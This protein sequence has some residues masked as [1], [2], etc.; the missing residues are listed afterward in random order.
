MLNVVN[1][2]LESLHFF[3]MTCC[4]WYGRRWEWLLLLRVGVLVGGVPQRISIMFRRRR[5]RQ[6]RHWT[7]N[8]TTFSGFDVIRCAVSRMFRW[9][10]GVYI[11]IGVGDRINFLGRWMKRK[12]RIRLLRC[13]RRRCVLIGGQGYCSAP[14][15]RSAVT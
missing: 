15:L 10:I 1:G 6:W 13:H 9:Y 2:R 5:Y 14:S 11:P 3:M 4:W 8:Y 7:G 12:K